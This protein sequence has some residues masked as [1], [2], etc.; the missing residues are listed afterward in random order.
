MQEIIISESFLNLLQHGTIQSI[1]KEALNIMYRVSLRPFHQLVFSTSLE[2][3][4]L[5]SMQKE[6]EWS[7]WD[8]NNCCLS[9]AVTLDR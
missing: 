5:R 6:K 8:F 1:I 4:E 9:I 3:T 7:R 2:G